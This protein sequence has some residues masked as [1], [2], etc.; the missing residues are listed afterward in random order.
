MF[1]LRYNSPKAWVD[2]VM[3]DFDTFLVDHAAAEKKASGMAV[4]MLS[5]Y[6]DRQELVMAMVDLSLEEMVHFR[7]VL[8]LMNKRGLILAP[9]T[10][11][12]YVNKLRKHMRQGS[13]LYMLDRLIIAGIIEA[14]GCER[15]GLIADALPEGELKGFYKAITE[16]EARHESLFIDLARTYFEDSVVDARLDELLDVEAEI[17]A[18][19]PIQ[20]ALH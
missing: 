14:R 3:N 18:A 6:P 2:A 4:S 19:L 7:D 17:C 10:K 9:D 16:S 20:A 5:H 8:K 12:A 1:K 11:D 13:E 15:F